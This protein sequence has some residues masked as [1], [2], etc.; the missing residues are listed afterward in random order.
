[1]SSPA[2]TTSGAR[3]SKGGPAAPT[4][5]A[6]ETRG[7]DETPVKRPGFFAGARHG[8]EADA[9]HVTRQG[10]ATARDGTP[11]YYE[12][13]GP[14]D[15][16]AP[17]IVLSDGIGCDGYV[18]KYLWPQLCEERATVHWHYRGHGKTPA[19]RDADC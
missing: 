13:G 12:L 8:E 7:D 3:R 18:W 2:K 9:S 15:Q 1:M 19:P 17:S 10:F 14:L 16:A 5:G 4:A 11:L 6:G